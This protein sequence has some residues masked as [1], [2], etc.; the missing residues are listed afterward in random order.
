MKLLNIP[1]LD[2]AKLSDVGQF[3]IQKEK[4]E[5]F[6]NVKL[7]ISDNARWKPGSYDKLK[8]DIVKAVF[9]HWYTKKGAN[10]ISKMTRYSQYNGDKFM[11]ELRQIDNGLKSLRKQSL[12]LTSDDSDE[13]V[14]K[15]LQEIIRNLSLPVDNVSVD[16]NP[17]PYFAKIIRN[18]QLSH[19]ALP[20]LGNPPPLAQLA[21]QCLDGEIDLTRSLRDK[22][23]KASINNVDAKKWWINISIYLPDISVN[24]MRRSRNVESFKY[25]GL[26]VIFSIPIYDMLKNYQLMK[27]SD[28]SGYDLINNMNIQYYGQHTYQHP[29]Y[30]VFHPFVKSNGMNNYSMGNSCFG[31]FFVEIIKMLTCGSVDALKAILNIWATTYDFANTTPL[32][33]VQSIHFGMNKHWTE[34]Q[35]SYL[36]TSVET[37]RRAITEGMSKQVLLDDFCSNCQ[38]AAENN[39]SQYADLTYASKEF[40][41]ELTLALDKVLQAEDLPNEGVH[42]LLEHLFSLPMVTHDTLYPIFGTSGLGTGYFNNEVIDNA[43]DNFNCNA[44]DG[45]TDSEMILLAKA[46]CQMCKI[47]ERIWWS[48][49]IK[50]YSA[51]LD[52]SMRSDHAFKSIEDAE[53]AIPIDDIKFMINDYAKR[54]GD[55]AITELIINIKE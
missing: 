13:R 11:S 24:Y 22:L 41:L 48:G 34:S 32:N 27:N 33:N 36:V 52:D 1:I 14:K 5:D 15:N 47:H 50:Y 45:M 51:S 7:D 42:R 19:T 21:P 6:Y 9:G 29:V 49:H 55:P 46:V 17:L 28:G 39:C 20:G 35:K 44:G 12:N 16:I 31:D 2:L 37:C 38:L 3:K 4:F 40:P 43:I 18:G 53:S 10:T 30:P 8:K 23:K 25:G 54:A 26:T